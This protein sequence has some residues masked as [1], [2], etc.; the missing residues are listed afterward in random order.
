[1]RRGAER[2]DR[3]VQTVAEHS[4]MH[5][6]TVK[7]ILSAENGMNLYRGCLH[8]CIYCDARSACYH[9][10]H[11]FE[12]IEV[13]SNALELLERAL[14]RKRKK[15]MIGT[16]SMSDPYLPLERQLGRTRAALELIAEYGFGAAVQTKSDLVLR[17]LDVLEKINARTKCVVQL[18][19]T[20]ADD[21]LC[22]IIEPNVAVTG[23]RFE[24]LKALQARGIPTVVW[25]T[26]ILPFINDTEENIVRILDYCIAAGVYGVICFDMGLTLRDGN[27]EYF[28]RKLD[29]HFPGLKERYVRQYGDRYV[30]SSPHSGAL[31]KLFHQ[32]CRAHGIVSDAD[33]VFRYLHRFEEKRPSGQLS[34]FS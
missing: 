2:T 18:T 8:G 25:L 16:G 32:I 4:A 7:G 6:V 29:A 24:V 13:K 12:D 27:R 26:P 30:L 14:A 28:Y 11:D 19:L 10:D 20:T 5:E 3:Q 23:R 1:M 17:D 31:M 9:I 34:L 33:A 21:A 22:R 15:C